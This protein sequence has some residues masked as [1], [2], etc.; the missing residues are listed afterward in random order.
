MSLP[1]VHM[2]SVAI[3]IDLL[4]KEKQKF[5]AFQKD[6]STLNSERL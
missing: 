4:D 6:E 5:L 1:M 3:I 2:L